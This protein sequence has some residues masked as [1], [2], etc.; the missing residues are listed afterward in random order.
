M[1]SS[2]GTRFAC[3]HCECAFSLELKR[4][5]ERGSREMR[6]MCSTSDICT[7]AEWRKPLRQQMR[8]VNCTRFLSHTLTH[9]KGCGSRCEQSQSEPLGKHLLHPL[10]LPIS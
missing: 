9:L 7:Q 1:Y 8:C 5:P 10:T 2:P 4:G 6:V 3:R